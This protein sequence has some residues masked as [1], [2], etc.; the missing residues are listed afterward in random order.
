MKNIAKIPHYSNNE[1]IRW[2]VRYLYNWCEI[3]SFIHCLEEFL[4]EYPDDITVRKI[5]I[6][7]KS[8]LNNRKKIIETFYK[9]DDLINTK[10]HSSSINYSQ[11][12]NLYYA[13]T[14]Y[15]NWNEIESF[16]YCLSEFLKDYPQDE[17]ILEIY[18]CAKSHL[19]ERE[20]L[21]QVFAEL[22]NLYY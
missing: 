18:N 9:L 21:R 14:Y 10:Y 2:A 6:S 8:H 17:N 3:E 12:D 22:E 4:K 11:N 20:S 1:N 16:V 19:D 7:V 15:Y 5:Y 13:S